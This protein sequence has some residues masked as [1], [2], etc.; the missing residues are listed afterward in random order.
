[1]VIEKGVPIARMEVANLVPL[2]TTDLMS[3]SQTQTM[4]EEER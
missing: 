2:V 1:M 3:K 4:S